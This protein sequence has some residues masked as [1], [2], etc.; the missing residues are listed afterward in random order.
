VNEETTTQVL[1]KIAISATPIKFQPS[2][3]AV[4]APDAPARIAIDYGNL[5][6]TVQTTV[7]LTARLDDRLTYLDSSPFTP[8]IAGPTL[9]WQLPALGLLDEQMINLRVQPPVAPLGTRFP[10]T[11]TLTAANTATLPFQ[12][13]TTVEV[14]IA[15]Q[16]YLPL[17]KR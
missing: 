9:T 17:I 10:V 8:T 16:S 12:S 5:S 7:T 2:A 1:W 6:A 4:A 3:L 15:A 13:S 11:L 14:M